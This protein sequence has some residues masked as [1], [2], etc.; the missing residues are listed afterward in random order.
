MPIFHQRHA[1]LDER[2]QIILE[3]L[4]YFFRYPYSPFLTNA[5]IVF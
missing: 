1:Y 4:K 5:D 2:P 3:W